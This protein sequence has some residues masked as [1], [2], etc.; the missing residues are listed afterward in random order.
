MAT[1][2]PTNNLTFTAARRL[3]VLSRPRRHGDRA[4]HG[5][6][7]PRRPTRS[8][9]AGGAGAGNGTGQNGNVLANTAAFNSANATRNLSIGTFNGDVKVGLGPVKLKVYGQLAYNFQG[10]ARDSQEY[11]QPRLDSTTDKLAF[12]TGLTRRLGLPDQEE[13]RLRVPRR[14][15]AGRPRLG[16]SEPQ[17]LG[18]EL[19]PPGLPRRQGRGQ[20]RLLSRG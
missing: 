20:L 2:K 17:R 16:R 6:A 3:P 14:I 11:G 15:P 13:G 19:Q 18:L 1:F 4:R 12:S 8:R 9:G 10:G 5:D 7:R